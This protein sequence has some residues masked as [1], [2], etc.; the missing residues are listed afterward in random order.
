V[1]T[2]VAP[3]KI[4]ALALVGFAAAFFV[5]IAGLVLGV[6]STRQLREP[7]NIET[8]RGLALCAIIIAS[9]SIAFEN[10]VVVL[11]LSVV[12]PVFSH[13]CLHS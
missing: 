4:N 10:A 2:P 7:T 6:I 3:A 13:I 8:G 11:W 5:A 12:G 1:S 9:A